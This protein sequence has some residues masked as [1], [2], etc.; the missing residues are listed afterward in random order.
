MKFTKTVPKLKLRHS[1][2]IRRHFADAREESHANRLREP[3]VAGRRPII[4]SS[5][6]NTVQKTREIPAQMKRRTLE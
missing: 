2:L 1:N 3:R 4:D 6:L 5:V